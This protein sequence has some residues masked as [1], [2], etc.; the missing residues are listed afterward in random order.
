MIALL[1]AFLMHAHSA[2]A[3]NNSSGAKQGN[4]R[5]T[6][7]T[8]EAEKIL[9]LKANAS[10]AEIESAFKRLI[11]INHPDKGGSEYIANQLIEARNILIHRRKK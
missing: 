11:K 10:D 9:G 4:N 8:C 2:S 7:S 5:E 6:I 3:T 1:Y